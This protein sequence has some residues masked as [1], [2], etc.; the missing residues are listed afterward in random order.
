MAIKTE[1]NSDKAKIIKDLQKEVQAL[2]KEGKIE[3]VKAR[4]SQPT[5]EESSRADEEMQARLEDL[6][7]EKVELQ[8]Q[9]N[10]AHA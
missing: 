3:R 7:Q 5:V 8:Q 2:K 10:M 1:Q 9:L 4:N 6:T